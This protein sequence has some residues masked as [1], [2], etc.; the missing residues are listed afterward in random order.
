[1]GHEFQMDLILWRHAE[2]EELSSD[3]IDLDRTLTA[4]GERQAQRMAQWLDQR[5]P[6]GTRVLVSPAKRAQQTAAALAAL[7]RK[8]KTIE[9]LSP[10]NSAADILAAAQWPEGRQPVVIVGHQPALGE[11]AA[12][13]IGGAPQSW[14]IKKG[15]AWWIRQRARG[16]SMQN[17]LIAVQ[18]PDFL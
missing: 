12:W 11:V 15:A 8:S 4:K 5:L 17:T 1:M 9:V 2:A 18:S 3:G 13:L 7:G 10:Q 16:E 14:T 6:T